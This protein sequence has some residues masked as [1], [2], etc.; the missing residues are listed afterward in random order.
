MTQV[1]E[2]LFPT[3]VVELPSKGLLYPSD[4]PLSSG[5]VEIK[6]MTAKEEDI[7]TTES[8]INQNV[9]I[10]KLLEAIITT[11]KVSYTDLLMGDRNA[12]MIAARIHGYGPDYTSQVRREDGS[13]TPINIHL[14]DIKHKEFDENL[15]S[16]G[17]NKFS[18]TLPISG[19][20]IEFKLLTVGEQHRITLD[21]K[22]MSKLGD[23]RSQGLTY[24]LKSM[25][26]SVDGKVEKSDI[27]K[28]VDNMR[29][30]DSRAFREYIKK[31]QPDVELNY[32]M[33]DPKSGESFR[34]DVE[35]GP[36]FFYPDYKG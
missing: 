19:N 18:F 28:F 23:K 21:L 25:I 31:I 15:V 9:V 6:Y 32:E 34:G 16:K 30:A 14:P 3:A 1:S 7:L 8:Y 35:I 22:G 10:D 24:R 20:V 17:E 13:T 5:Q 12:I 11:P 33:E 4:S 36:D 2:Q 29:V 27:A 26:T